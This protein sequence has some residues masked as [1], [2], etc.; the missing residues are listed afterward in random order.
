MKWVLVSLAIPVAMLLIVMIIGYLLPVEHHASVKCTVNATPEEVWKR[1][2]DIGSYPV[3]RTNVK[4]VEITSP[5]SWMETNKRNEELPFRILERR[6]PSKLVTVI[7]DKSSPYGGSW[8][9]DIQ[10]ANGKT[11]VT[12]IENGEV[13]NPFFRFVSKFI[14]GHTVTLRTYA[15]NLQRSFGH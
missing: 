1:L 4:S 10:P 3:W 15:D 8:E 2:A 9:F 13:Y 12:I 5:V 7:D 14:L 6:E 11:L